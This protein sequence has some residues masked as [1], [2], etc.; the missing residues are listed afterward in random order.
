MKIPLYSALVALP[1]IMSCSTTELGVQPN[2]VDSDV[3]GQQAFEKIFRGA[4]EDMTFKLTSRGNARGRYVVIQLNVETQSEEELSHEK[5]SY[6]QEWLASDLSETGHFDTISTDFVNVVMDAAGIA[7]H[8][9]LQLPA[10]RRLFLEQLEGEGSTP[11]FLLYP[12]ITS[13]RTKRDGTFRDV[14]QVT[15]KVSLRLVDARNGQEVVLG[16]DEISKNYVE[17][18]F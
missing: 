17:G 13:I 1:L 16:Y 2:I 8:K 15:Y 10:K 5:H 11:D 9:L 14:E 4:V 3:A 7:N 12:K 6:L 18:W